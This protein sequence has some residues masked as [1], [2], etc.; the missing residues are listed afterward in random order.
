MTHFRPSGEIIVRVKVTGQTLNTRFNLSNYYKRRSFPLAY[1]CRKHPLQPLSIMSG[2]AQDPILI[3]DEEEDKVLPVVRVSTGLGLSSH[4]RSCPS[5]QSEVE[6]Y[7]SCFPMS[8]E[9]SQYKQ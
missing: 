2:T 3:E 7:V 9:F 1:I 4:T 5:C 6:I 8:Y